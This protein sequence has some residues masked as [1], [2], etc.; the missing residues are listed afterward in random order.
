M[1]KRMTTLGGLAVGGM[2][3]VLLGSGTAAVAATPAKVIKPAKPVPAVVTLT[4][5]AAHVHVWTAPNKN[6][7]LSKIISSI[8][9][10][11]TAVTIACFTPGQMQGGDRTWYKITAPVA[12]FVSGHSLAITTEPAPGVPHC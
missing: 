8:K 12:G 4:T 10:A 11:G 2:L 5:N 3:A 1:T 7:K 6:P 9:V